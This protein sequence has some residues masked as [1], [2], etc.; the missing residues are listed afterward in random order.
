[1]EKT[2]RITLGP[3]IDPSTDMGPVVSA[4]AKADILGYVDS[5]REEG[6]TL[7]AGGGV[8]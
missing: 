3:G 7:L 4:D 8:P 5:A 6:A 1:V 2:E